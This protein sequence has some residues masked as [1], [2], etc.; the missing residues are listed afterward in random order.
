MGTEQDFKILLEKILSGKDLLPYEA[1]LSMQEIM[2]GKAGDAKTAAFLTALRIKG[3]KADEIAAFA[4]VLRANC[5]PV[6]FS[7]PNLL[8][9]CGTGG[10][11]FGTFNISTCSALVCA[12]A[13]AIVA[14]HGNRAVSGKSGSA[15]VLET[16]GV[17]IAISPQIAQSQLE[18]IGISFLFAP[19]FHPALKN[20]GPLRRE[21]GFRTVFNILGPLCNPA[22]PAK[23]VIGV[24]SPRIMGE[25]AGAL[26]ILGT[27]HSLVVCSDCDEISISQ[28]TQILEIK[29][30]KILAYSL[31]PE[32][33]GFKKCE[34]NGII[35]QNS[36]Q[37]AEIILGILKGKQGPARDVVLLNSAAAIYA[38]DR[39]PTIAAG[40]AMAEKSIDSGAALEKLEMLKNFKGAV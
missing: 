16:L 29:G 5:I 30:K 32:Q 19:N 18:T 39:A 35:A 40:L 24:F 7:N 15:D 12:G 20:L 1:E 21:L 25:Y 38:C 10:D 22:R 8:D 37:S 2:A 6:N 23:Q 28:D 9:T 14:K 31:S 26:S 34:K 4:K 36:A 13:G 33:F 11:G 3:E 27:E 17:Q